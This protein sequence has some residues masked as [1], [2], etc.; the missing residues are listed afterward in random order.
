[1]LQR[2][3]QIRTQISQ[4]AD[5]F[6][7]AVSFWLAFV[8]RADPQIS[9]WL[10]LDPI[11]GDTLNQDAKLIPVAMI[12]AAFL[13]ESQGFYSLPVLCPRRLILWPLFKGC[14]LTTMVLILATFLFQKDLIP[15]RLVMTFF[16]FI[17][18]ALIYCKEELLRLAF[19]SRFGQGQF[20]RRFI[21]VG[22][23]TETARMC[24]ELEGRK[25]E[26]VAVIAQFNLANPIPQLVE[27]LHD[28]AIYGV[29]L[30][31]KHT[32]FERIENVI[33]V[34]E[35]EGV[36]VWLVADFFTT[37]ISRTS[38]D[39]LLG[40]PLL[41]FRTAPEA[42]WAGLVKQLMDFFGALVLLLVAAP[43][44]MLPVAVFIKLFSPGPVFF[45]QQR[46]GLNGA[47][48]T[49]YKFRTMVTNAEQFKHELEA[50]NE[51]SGPVF[52]VT[53]DPRV[54]PLGKILR[55]YSLDELPQLFNVLRGEMSLVGPRP[56]PVDEV[57]RFNDLA[58]RRRLSVKPGIT[59][60]W[61]VSGRNQIA[62]FKEWV[63]LD[64]EYIDNWSLWLDI[65]ILL[66]TIPAVFI[67]TGAK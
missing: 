43:L 44:V 64:L 2:D 47:P 58:H 50:M 8:L 19:K 22:T 56:L 7:V 29:I 66:R 48:F 21:L 31:G 3:R 24:Q 26:T 55:R 38:F 35:L 12:A 62:D 18:F 41:I 40:R 57:R 67:A 59:C 9:A 4:F 13:L 46:S 45:R 32:Y 61:Q 6:L 42:S 30:S 52:K 23:E 54:T 65:K 51:M 16:G 15:S 17:S 39:E 5:A 49:L 37:Q 14:A 11:S 20:K 28:H 63:R 10:R 25:D 36:E 34:C 60:L 1:M 33:K 53:K 27:L